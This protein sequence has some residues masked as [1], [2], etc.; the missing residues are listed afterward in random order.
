MADGY[1]ADIDSLASLRRKML[2]TVPEARK[3]LADFLSHPWL[4]NYRGLLSE[5]FLQVV[6]NLVACMDNENTEVF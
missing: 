1:V 5:K 2:R 3:R 4:L 6:I